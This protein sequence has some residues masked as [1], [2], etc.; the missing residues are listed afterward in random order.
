[1]T[2]E[3][4]YNLPKDSETAAPWEHCMLA[5]LLLRGLYF[6]KRCSIADMAMAP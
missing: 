2:A 6:F 5:I 3:G 4:Q 1:M